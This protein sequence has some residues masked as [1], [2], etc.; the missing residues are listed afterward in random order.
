MQ[1]T[2]TQNT[3]LSRFDFND[4]MRY[5]SL[6]LRFMS[7]AIMY[8]DVKS[9]GIEED[10]QYGYGLIMEEL[11]EELDECVERLESD[12]GASNEINTTKL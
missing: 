7:D 3:P 8:W 9:I 1:N 12:K 4:K 2:T 6:K 10:T 5:I 11:I